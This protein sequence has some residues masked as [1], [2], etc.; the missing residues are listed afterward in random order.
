MSELAT[1]PLTGTYVA[2]PGPSTFAFKVRHSGT[3]WFRGVMPEARATLRADA[4]GLVLEGAA[5][6]ESIS[7]HEPPQMRAHLLAADF[8]DAATHPE[9]TFRSTDLRLRDDGCLD[10]DG[11]LTIKGITSPIKAHGHWSGPRQ[12]AFGEIAGLSLK[13]AFDRRDFG[14]DWQAEMPDGGDALGWEVELEVD[15]MLMPGAAEAEA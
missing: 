5:K 10:L 11:E 14:F 2:S 9:I 4:G 13:T 15:L 12:A 3:F 7:V 6:A 8:F 1:Q